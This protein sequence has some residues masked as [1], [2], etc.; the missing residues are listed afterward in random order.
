MN[1]FTFPFGFAIHHLGVLREDRTLVEKP[2]FFVGVSV[3]SN[4]RVGYH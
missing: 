2:F 1:L 3:H 4:P